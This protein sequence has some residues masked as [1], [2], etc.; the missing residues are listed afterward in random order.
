[1]KPNVWKLMDKEYS[2]V[3]GECAERRKGV[4]Y[5]PAGYY[6]YIMHCSGTGCEGQSKGTA[7]WLDKDTG[8]THYYCGCGE[9]CDPPKPG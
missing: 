6:R 9:L 3:C 7:N 4:V 8:R 1:M 2:Y 5:T